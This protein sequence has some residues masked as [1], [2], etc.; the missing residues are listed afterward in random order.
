MQTVGLF[1]LKGGVGKTTAAVNLA[2]LAAHAGH[3][4]LLWDLDPQG[5]AS[6]LYQGEPQRKKH[7]KKLFEG[8]HPVG[9]FITPTAYERLDL[10]PANLSG[11]HLDRLLAGQSE[12]HERLQQL[13]EPLAEEY[14]LVIFDCPPSLSNLAMNVF[15]AADVLLMP[16]LP[17]PL[18]LRAYEQVIAQ[19]AKQKL[20]RIK[21]YPFLTMVD[22]RRQLHR[23]MLET[24]P[25]RIKT[26]LHTTVPYSAVVERMGVERAP[27]PAFAPKS[28]AGQAYEALWQEARS[29]LAL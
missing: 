12:K 28:P 14:A 7:A 15:H 19:L 23:Q 25:G 2:W 21:L 24:L 3:R 10:I 20:R 4:T 18:A 26:L 6:W 9:E 22:R 5:A 27:L 16:L 29:L 1:N 17:S 11:R 13:L 8:A